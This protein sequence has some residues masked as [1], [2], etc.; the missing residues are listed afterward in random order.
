MV[1]G[2]LFLLMNASL[3]HAVISHTDRTEGQSDSLSLGQ[4]EG[5]SVTLRQRGSNQSHSQR[6]S[7]SNGQTAK[8][9]DR[10]TVVHPARQR[11]SHSHIQTQVFMIFNKRHMYSHSEMSESVVIETKR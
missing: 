5:Q 4:P 11:D 7:Q 3:S 6:G 10:A 8:K 2:S 9:P 1:F